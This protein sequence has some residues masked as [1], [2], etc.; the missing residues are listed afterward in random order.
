[1]HYSGERI[2]VI[3]IVGAVA[4][5]LGGKLLR[6]SGLGVVGDGAVGIVGSLIGDWLLPRFHIHLAGG[7]MG[8]VVNAAIGAVAVILVARVSGAGGGGR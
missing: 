2:L 1:M 7:L 5:F 4:G 8:L 3:L 6:G